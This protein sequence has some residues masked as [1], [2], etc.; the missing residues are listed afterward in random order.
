MGFDYL[1]IKIAS[2]AGTGTQKDALMKPADPRGVHQAQVL[3]TKRTEPTEIPAP[4]EYKSRRHPN[5]EEN[6]QT[7]TVPVP[8]QT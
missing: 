8:P 4:R 1:T 3:N 5:W 2:R 7:H 6:N